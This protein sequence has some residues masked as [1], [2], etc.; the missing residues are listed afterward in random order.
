MV[1]PMTIAISQSQ[2]LDMPYKL[3]DLHTDCPGP[4]LYLKVISSHIGTL[5][6]NPDCPISNYIQNPA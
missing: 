4:Q 2:G 6:G 5:I 3:H 1:Q